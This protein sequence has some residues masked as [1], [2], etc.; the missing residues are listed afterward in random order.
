M[1]RAFQGVLNKPANTMCKATVPL[2]TGMAVVVDEVSGSVSLPGGVMG[3]GISFVDKERVPVGIN[4]ARG[5]M[6]DYD[7]QF[8]EVAE[9]E[10]VKVISFLPMTDIFGTDQFEEAGLTANCWVVANE[11]GKMVKGEGI[12][13]L[14]KFIQFYEDNGHKLAMIKKVDAYIGS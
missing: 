1:L 12:E 2:K 3:M 10:L 9:D 7:P 8:N 6:S 11:S 14:Y 4:T 5:D 13:T